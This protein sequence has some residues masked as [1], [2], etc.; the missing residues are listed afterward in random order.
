MRQI[1]RATEFSTLMPNICGSSVWNL[2]YHVILLAPSLLVIFWKI[3]V[4]LIL[5]KIM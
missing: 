1:A 4:P 3:S 2:W 5:I